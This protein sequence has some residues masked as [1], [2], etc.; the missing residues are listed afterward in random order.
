M[1][2]EFAK[3]P[4][5]EE[6]LNDIR[7]AT[8]SEEEKLIVFA[9]LH[10]EAALREASENAKVIDVGIDYAI[11]EW[12]VDKSSILNSYPPENIK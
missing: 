11:E 1:E 4:T 7:N 2:R 6:F 3:A 12:V 10:V 5:A 8:Y 9:R